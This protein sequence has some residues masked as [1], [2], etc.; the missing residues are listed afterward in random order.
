MIKKL[1]WTIDQYTACCL[2]CLR[3]VAQKLFYLP[4]LTTNYLDEILRVNASGKGG[5]LQQ[6]Y[7]RT[8]DKHPAQIKWKKYLLISR[9]GLEWFL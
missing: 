3:N 2:T 1:P 6:F 8:I 7:L 5:K 4:Y 9:S